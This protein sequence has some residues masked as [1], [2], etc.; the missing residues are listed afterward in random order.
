[1]FNSNEL[2]L[3]LCASFVCCEVDSRKSF[4][5]SEESA[6]YYA[7]MFLLREGKLRV[8]QN[9]EVFLASP[10]DAVLVCPGVSRKVEKAGEGPVRM[11]LIRMDPDRIPGMPA[12]APS[13]KEILTKAVREKL[14]ML[15]SAAEAR[16][17]A[18]PEMTGR[19][20]REAEELKFGFDLSIVSELG[21]ICSAVIR[22]WMS[23]GLVVRKKAG[24]ARTET[25]E[26]LSGYIQE[27]MRDNLRVE[28][29]A[30]LCGMSYPWFAKKFRQAYGV[31]CKDFIE[32]IRVNQ[33]G[34][35]LLFTDMG[36]EEISQET[37]YADCSH[38][39]K[40]FKRIMGITPGQFRLRHR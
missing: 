30:D 32:Q 6:S 24:K 29:L 40:N 22:Y 2:C 27:H 31:N 20:V 13:L 36:L 25:V 14:P 11:D 7:E 9:E 15:V 17:M 5:S 37:G 3:P 16:E 1:M 39:I 8:S 35:Y 12:Y 23:R 38:M 21:L 4:V 19:C 34:K 26:S 33:V 10:G 18:L 28:D